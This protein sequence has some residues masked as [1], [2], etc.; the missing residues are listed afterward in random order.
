MTH[1]PFQRFAIIPVPHG[2][3]PKEAIVVGPMSTV[4]EYIPQSVARADAM[5]ELERARFTA[6]QIKSIQSKTRGVQVAMLT[7]SVSHLSRRIDAFLTRKQNQA[8][9]DAAREA[10][11]EAKRIQAKLDA[12]P[13]PDDPDAHHPSGELHTLPPS[14]KLEP[15]LELEDGDQTEFPDPE[16]PKPPVLEQSTAISLNKE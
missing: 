4:M 12:L 11:E 6:D 10:E 3:A 16:L 2:P 8:R 1:D 15:S 5:A 7:D 9:L 14:V 13:D